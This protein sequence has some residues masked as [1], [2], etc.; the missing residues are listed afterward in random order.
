MENMWIFWLIL[1]VGLIIVELCTVNVTTVW[2]ALGALAAMAI[3]LL[4]NSV[5]WVQLLIFVCVSIIMLLLARKFFL[6]YIKKA[7]VPTNA[8]AL[9]GKV[10]IVTEAIDNDQNCGRVAIEGLT[11][12]A[13]SV[14]GENV[15]INEKVEVLS[16]QGVKLIVKKII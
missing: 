16:I 10:A 3:S 12:S 5:F 8:D 4:P 7:P 9:I 2:F 13:R 6:K 1:T 15:D 14:D 11:W